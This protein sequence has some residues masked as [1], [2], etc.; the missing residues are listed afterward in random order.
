MNRD[1]IYFHSSKY[2]AQILI[3]GTAVDSLVIL[4]MF[5]WP[6]CPTKLQK[7]SDF[8]AQFL[9]WLRKILLSQIRKND[10]WYTIPLSG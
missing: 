6:N 8:Q 1:N 4:H 5:A 3:P 2:I 9:N 7:E 10:A